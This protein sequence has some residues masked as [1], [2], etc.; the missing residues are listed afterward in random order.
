MPLSAYAGLSSGIVLCIDDNQ[1]VLEC[2]KAFLETYGY[3]VL[4][5]PSGGKGLELASIHSVDV[6]I[7]DYFMPEM[8]GPEVAIE[9]RR[10]RPQ[11][12]IIMLSA[13]LD[14]PAGVLKLVDAFVAKDC[15][16]SQLLPVIAKLHGGRSI[17]PPSYDA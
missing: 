4:T 16:A 9:M 2:A 1:D 5:A 6:V 3:T 11:A 14:I 13:A 12:P 17:S 7:V 10:L 8:N 15:L